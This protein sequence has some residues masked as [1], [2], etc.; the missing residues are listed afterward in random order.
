[1]KFL[2]IH[3][4]DPKTASVPPSKEHMAEKGKFVEASR[5]QGTPLATGMLLLDTVLRWKGGVNRSASM[6]HAAHA[7]LHTYS[8]CST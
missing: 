6:R 8:P 5:K 1:M 7:E 3:T 2:S 4:P